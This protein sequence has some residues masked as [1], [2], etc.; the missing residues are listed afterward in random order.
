MSLDWTYNQLKKHASKV[1]IREP[2]ASFHKHFSEMA[3]GRFNYSKMPWLA[4]HK[5][6]ALAKFVILHGKTGPVTVKPRI[7]DYDYARL[8]NPFSKLWKEAEDKYEYPAD[9]L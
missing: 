9:P 8:L 5:L 2:L 3:T 7:K 1:K 6:A 4:A